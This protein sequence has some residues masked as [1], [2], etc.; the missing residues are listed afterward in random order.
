[1]IIKPLNPETYSVTMPFLS[2]IKMTYLGRFYVRKLKRY[3][4]IR[5]FVLTLWKFFIR[6]YHWVYV[7]Y[8]KLKLYIP[9]QLQ[10]SVDSQYT[11]CS[12]AN[13]S[14]KKIQIFPRQFCTI[15]LP[16]TYPPKGNDF[17]MIR[18]DFEFPEIYIATLKNF[19]VIG[20]SKL[21]FNETMI[22]YDDLLDPKLD[23]MPEEFQL[24][25]FLNVKKSLAFL[26]L[27]KENPAVIPAGIAFT[28]ALSNNYAHF[29]TEILPKIAIYFKGGLDS[30]VKVIID[31]CLHE[32]ILHAME[33]VVGSN[34]EVIGL[35]PNETVFVRSL[36]VMSTCGSVPF[37]PKIVKS[38]FEGYSNGE[39]SSLAL[40]YM[41]NLIQSKI[42]DVPKAG[43]ALKLYI[44]RNSSYR[45]IIN[46]TEVEDMLL[47]NG[48]IT[49]S[50]EAMSFIE[51]VKVFSNADIVIGPTG[52]GFANIIF[53]KPETKII[54]FMPQ[55]QST[56][57]GYWQKI[58][59]AVG[60]QVSYLL[61]KPRNKHDAHSNYYVDESTLFT[62]VGSAI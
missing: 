47:K 52:S 10:H 40:M 57:Y 35:K 62:L 28:D 50:P 6:I 7:T 1:M 42:S 34:L 56:P 59:C 8:H 2:C 60:C 49:I 43:F 51:Q 25:L 3:F 27:K 11:L 21:I 39:F 9:V 32:N 45:N 24:R 17:L 53:C 44:K 37:E 20:S 41:R 58:A 14:T 61:C 12:L 13:F 26:N 38:D 33:I 36:H 54:I 4:Y 29:L 46:S 15:P 55:V 16:E 31:L 22:L 19:T 30:S 18:T 5:L 48:F 23:L